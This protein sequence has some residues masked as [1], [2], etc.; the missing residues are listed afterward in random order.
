MSEVT[1]V[2]PEFGLPGGR[3][4]LSLHSF[5]CRKWG[6]FCPIRTLFAGSEA[7]LVLPELYLSGVRQPVSFQCFIFQEWGNFCPIITLFA[8]S[9]ANLVLP[10]LCLPGVRQLV[11]FQSFICQEMRQL[12]SYQNLVCQELG[13]SCPG[14]LR[15]SA[16]HTFTACSK[17]S[18]QFSFSVT[19]DQD[20]RHNIEQQLG[21]T[22]SK[23]YVIL[24]IG[25]ERGEG[26]WNNQEVQCWN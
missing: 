25:A 5:I 18:E 10:E 14:W 3:Q 1:L 9:E 20:C 24:E 15:P 7:N 6:N 12:L 22:P 11:S 23:I 4:L 2:L 26:V 13:N 17:D 16:R 21:R 19:A 8:G